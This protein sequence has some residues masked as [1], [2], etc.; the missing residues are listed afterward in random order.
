MIYCHTD[1]EDVLWVEFICLVF[2]VMPGD[3]YARRF[4]SVL[5]CPSVGCLSSA[6][7]SLCLLMQFLFACLFVCCFLP[8]TG[9]LEVLRWTV[10]GDSFFLS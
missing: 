6:I 1:V 2:T 7:S 8:S 5:S 3:S 9:S 10:C 4:R